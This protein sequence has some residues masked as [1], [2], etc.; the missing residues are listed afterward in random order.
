MARA[1][2]R[3]SDATAEERKLFERPDGQPYEFW[4]QWDLNKMLQQELTQSIVVRPL[5]CQSHSGST[6]SL[7]GERWAYQ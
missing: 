1:S 4:I 6:E 5:I 7:I 3:P 2:T